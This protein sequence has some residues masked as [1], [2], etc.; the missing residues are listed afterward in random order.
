MECDWNNLGFE[1]LPNNGFAQTDYA[2]GEWGELRLVAGHEISLHVAANCLHYGQACFEGLKAF[3]TRD[4]RVVMFRPG[5]NARRMIASAE[6]ICMAPAPEELFLE[7]CCMAVKANMEYVPPYG[8]G[9][10]MYIRPLLLGTQGMFPVKASQTYSFLVLVSPVGP[11]YKHGFKPVDAVVIDQYD[12]A[13]PK[14]TGMSKI[15]GNYAAGLKGT[16]EAVAM[17]YAI[18]LYLDARENR[19]VDEFG[20]SN[21]IG[22][23]ADGVYKTPDSESILPSVTNDSLR[24][25]AEEMGLRVERGPIEL[26]EV[27]RF[28][29]VGACGTA[30][31]ITPVRSITRAEKKYRFGD[32]DR[33]GPTLTKLYEALQAIQCGDVEDRHNWLY[34]VK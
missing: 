15:A 12:R 34:E 2:G 30:A 29:E 22:I 33:A 24:T 6:R 19:Y 13:A 26:E 11:Y 14:G 23:T 28:A 25:L 20:T 21:F 7:A 8:T 32:P 27:E 3:R 1:C 5:M 9:A 18:V 17:G 31:V 10:S 16:A 4:G